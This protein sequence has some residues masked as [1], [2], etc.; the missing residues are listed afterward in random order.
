[1]RRKSSVI[2]F[3]FLVMLMFCSISFAAKA[4]KN[5]RESDAILNTELHS[6]KRIPCE[7]PCAI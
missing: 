7:S 5:G 4:E 6:A 2:F 1:M 3:L